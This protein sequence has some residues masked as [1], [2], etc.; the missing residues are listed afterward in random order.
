MVRVMNLECFFS[1]RRDR[2]FVLVFRAL[3]E[4]LVKPGRGRQ[5]SDQ[6]AV[7][8][9]HKDSSLADARAIGAVLA[10][11]HDVVPFDRP[12]VLQQRLVDAFLG[13]I[14]PSAPSSAPGGRLGV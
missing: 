11:E 3:R 13:G 1:W 5:G 7:E 12:H 4:G 10:V 9:Q 8:I 2:I 6:I 14:G